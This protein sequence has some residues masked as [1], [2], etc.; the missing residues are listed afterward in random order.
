MT[1]STLMLP[2]IDGEQV[3]RPT[4]DITNMHGRQTLEV[5]KH[6]YYISCLAAITLVESVKTNFFAKVDM[7]KDG[8]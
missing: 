4:V 7:M 3:I 1:M 8:M 5:H 6:N 2:V